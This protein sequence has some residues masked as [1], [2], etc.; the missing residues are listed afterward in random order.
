MVSDGLDYLA[1]FIRFSLELS[2]GYSAA[3][4]V[5][6]S[7]WELAGFTCWLLV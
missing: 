5:S 7:I 4:G 6:G 3:M 2:A 1:D